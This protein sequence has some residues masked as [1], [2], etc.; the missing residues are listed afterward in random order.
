MNTVRNL[1]ID[2]N[3]L[4]RRYS[5]GAT[6]RR[7]DD[8]LY[9][10]VGT[11]NSCMDSV[12]H[13][14]EIPVGHVI[15]LIAQTDEPRFARCPIWRADEV[16]SY[17][18]DD[19]IY[20]KAGRVKETNQHHEVNISA[21][22]NGATILGSGVYAPDDWDKI[23]AMYTAGILPSPWIDGEYLRPGVGGMTS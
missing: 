6:V 16:M 20:V 18:T 11:G 21:C 7:R 4:T 2:P 22:V 5:W 3:A 19:D 12:S 23:L 15:V 1:D 13:P 10:Y 14:R 9:T 17:Q 8:G